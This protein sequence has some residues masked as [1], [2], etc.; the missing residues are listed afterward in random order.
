MSTKWFNSCE[1]WRESIKI[2]PPLTTRT[3][4]IK[5]GFSILKDSIE[6]FS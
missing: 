3:S 4:L 2:G 5:K 6:N 1:N